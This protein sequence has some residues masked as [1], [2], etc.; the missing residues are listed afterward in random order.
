MSYDKEEG[1]RDSHKQQE[2]QPRCST[3]CGRKVKEHEG[4]KGRCETLGNDSSLERLALNISS[5]NS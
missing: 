2:E 1:R 3:C 4:A 5:I